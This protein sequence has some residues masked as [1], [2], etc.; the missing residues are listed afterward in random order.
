MPGENETITVPSGPGGNET[1]TVPTYPGGN[2]TQTVS[3]GTPPSGTF[4]IL[5]ELGLSFVASW[6]KGLVE[7]NVDSVYDYILETIAN[8]SRITAHVVTELPGEGDEEEGVVYF[9]ETFDGSGVY[10]QYMFV[11]DKWIGLGST[12]MDLTNHW[13]RDNLKPMSLARIQTIIDEAEPFYED[14]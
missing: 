14:D 9:I 13:T 3:I 11:D 5:D 2:E 8:I 1:I 4:K 12:N 6:V 10:N 7:S